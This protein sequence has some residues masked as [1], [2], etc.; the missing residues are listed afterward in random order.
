MIGNIFDDEYLN[1][2]NKLIY[3][4]LCVQKGKQKI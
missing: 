1:E 2:Y 3:N 4:D